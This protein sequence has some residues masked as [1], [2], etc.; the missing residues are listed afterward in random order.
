MVKDDEALD[1]Q[2]AVLVQELGVVGYEED[3]KFHEFVF[4][5]LAALRTGLESEAQVR[6]QADDEIVNA[7]NHY[8]QSVQEAMRVVNQAPF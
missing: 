1:G 2:V 3:R 6:E 8:T 4:T 7:L 5:E